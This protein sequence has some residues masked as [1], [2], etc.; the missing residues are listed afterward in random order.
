MA[1]T[2]QGMT[3]L[4]QVFDMQRS[5][6]FYCDKLGFELVDKA[7]PDD[8]IGWVTIQLNEVYL[9]LN[10]QYEKNDRPATRDQGRFMAHTDTCLYFS[11]ADPDEIY[12]H[13]TQK[14]II[15]EK[16]KVVPYGMKQLYF[17]DP[18]GYNICFQSKV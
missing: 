17:L 16:P 9:M 6:Q 8:D 12:D 2:T 5:L 1:I 3:T 11:C 10:T 4:L 7:G 18:D 15:A 14:G 13:I